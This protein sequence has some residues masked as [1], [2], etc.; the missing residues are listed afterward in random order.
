ML[1]TDFTSLKKR[2]FVN[3]A[4]F[5]VINNIYPDEDILAKTCPICGM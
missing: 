3:F 2:E 1:S 5:S 4:N